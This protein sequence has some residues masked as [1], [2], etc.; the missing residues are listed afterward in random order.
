[1]S[2]YDLYYIKYA[3]KNEKQNSWYTCQDFLFLFGLTIY[4]Q[5]LRFNTQNM[6]HFS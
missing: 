6:G 1:M 4:R 2:Y 3:S 5:L